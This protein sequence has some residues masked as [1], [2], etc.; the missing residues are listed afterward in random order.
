VAKIHKTATIRHHKWLAIV[1]TLA[2]TLVLASCGGGGGGGG[3]T[4]APTSVTQTV[5]C[6]NGTSKSGTGTTT[7]TAIDAATAQCAGPALVS[8]SPTDGITSVAADTFTGVEVTTDS[9]LDSSTLTTT[10]VTLKAGPTAIAGTVSA[11]G[12]KGFK[13][14]PTAKLGNGQA[15]SFSATVKDTLGKPLTVTSTFTTMVVTCVAP[16]M[17]NGLGGCMAPPA[18]TGYTWNIVLRA[19]VADIGTLVVGTNQL[20]AGCVLVGDACWNQ[21]IADGTIKLANS[22]LVLTGFNTRPIVFA[23]YRAGTGTAFTGVYL[24]LPLYADAIGDTP[25]FVKNAAQ[26]GVKEMATDVKGSSVGLKATFTSGCWEKIFSQTS[27]SFLTRSI[28][29][30]I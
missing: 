30:P 19:W 27:A 7:S 13:F 10:N 15:Y 26:D 1:A 28:A 22:G 21:S 23:F 14:A 11:V 29:C 6:P 5:T 4:P 20:P 8:I 17:L 12:T 9:T 24:T 2:G 16:A 25:Q 18:V 3:G